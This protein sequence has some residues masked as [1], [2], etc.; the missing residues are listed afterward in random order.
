MGAVLDVNGV[1]VQLIGGRVMN[2]IVELG[3]FVGLK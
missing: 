3:S 1:R 2:G